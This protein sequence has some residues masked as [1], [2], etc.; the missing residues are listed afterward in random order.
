MGLGG[1]DCSSGIFHQKLGK[2]KIPGADSS[3]VEGRRD[4][5]TCKRPGGQVAKHV[6][7]SGGKPGRCSGQAAE[8]L[9]L[10]SAD[11]FLCAASKMV[12]NCRYW[13]LVQRPMPGGER[14]GNHVRKTGKQDE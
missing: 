8:P 11:W 13:G 9:T 6:S 1:E 4:P 5:A 14:I 3:L 12:M 7:L 10:F 2:K